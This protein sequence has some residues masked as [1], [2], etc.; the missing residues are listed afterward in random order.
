MQG[1]KGNTVE[2]MAENS[3]PTGNDFFEMESSGRQR[4]SSDHGVKQQ[5]YTKRLPRATNLGT[6]KLDSKTFDQKLVDRAFEAI[7]EL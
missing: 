2:Q 4:Y 7:S 1:N 6:Q 5:F 3:I